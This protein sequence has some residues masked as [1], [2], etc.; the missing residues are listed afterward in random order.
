MGFLT[1]FALLVVLAVALPI[2]M[3]V[4]ECLAAA[5][6]G[7][8]V[9]GGASPSDAND[10]RTAILIPAHDE[11]TEIAATLR[12]LQDH[13]GESHRVFVVAHNCTDRTAEIARALGAEVL[14]ARDDGA[15]GKPSA[16][17]AGLAALAADPPEI[18][19]TLD[20]DC[21]VNP[22]GIATLA[23]TTREHAAP[24][25][26]TYL[27][28]GPEARS[29]MQAVSRLALLVKNL[30]RPLGLRRLGLP[31]VLNGSGC[32]FP[33]ALLRDALAGE[34]GI[35]E[36]R[37][38]SVDLALAGHPP[39][40][41]PDVEVWSRLPADRGSAYEQRRRWEHGNLHVT[42]FAAPPLLW[43][44]LRRARPSLFLFGLDLLIP[45]LAFLVLLWGLATAVAAGALLAGGVALPLWISGVA[46]GALFLGVTLVSLR[47]EGI[48]ETVRTMVF[49]P[50]YVAWKIP[51]YVTY[52]LRRE[53]RWIRTTRD[54]TPA[55]PV[56]PEGARPKEGET[57]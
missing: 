10:P 22:G 7:R 24:V 43:A 30:A 17:R 26:G 45:P 46:G 34:G 16:L 20:A 23:R 51:L 3:L 21:T 29:W 32:G 14:E 40:Y 47:F 9:L 28:R 49:I 52:I 50:L 2:A 41:C 56:P 53:T 25:Q 1:A 15:E 54:G 5:L 39:L 19:I 37:Q 42:F 31:C 55:E 33:F 6:G 18:V 38:Y 44:G 4:V 27:F 57:R 8:H 48:A 13:V 35:V 11:E 36:D 12:S